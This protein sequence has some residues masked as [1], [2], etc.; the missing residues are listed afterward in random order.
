MFKDLI[1][2]FV[3]NAPLQANA[4][5]FVLLFKCKSQREGTGEVFDPMGSCCYA[6]LLFALMQRSYLEG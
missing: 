6:D 4:V 1:L 3:V 2:E 5:N